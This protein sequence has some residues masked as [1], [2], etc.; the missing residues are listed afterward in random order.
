MTVN[1]GKVTVSIKN[2]SNCFYGFT[3]VEVQKPEEF[4]Q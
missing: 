2:D 1:Q 4:K 3:K